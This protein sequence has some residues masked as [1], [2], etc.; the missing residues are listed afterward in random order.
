[1]IRRNLLKTLGAIGA[2]SIVPT[3]T[4]KTETDADPQE[5]L[6]KNILDH[7]DAPHSRIDI[8][9]IGENELWVT[10]QNSVNPLEK[11]LA[12]GDSKVHIGGVNATGARKIVVQYIYID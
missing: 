8:Q 7:R 9:E 6:K 3:A 2:G 4:A 5:Y 10:Y 1:M 11:S 12:S